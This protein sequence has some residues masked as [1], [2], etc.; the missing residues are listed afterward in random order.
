MNGH[1]KTIKAIRAA[2]AGIPLLTIQAFPL[3]LNY[4]WESMITYMVADSGH[5][6]LPITTFYFSPATLNVW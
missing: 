4:I 3:P 5:W 2:M 6:Q 1:M